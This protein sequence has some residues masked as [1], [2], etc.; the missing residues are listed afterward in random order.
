MHATGLQKVLGHLA[1]LLFAALISG[2]FSIGHLAAPYIDPTALTAARF[3]LAAMVMGLLGIVVRRHL[4]LI[5]EAPWRFII[6]G[7]L[8][9][10]YFV[11][12]FYGLKIASPVSMGAVF[13]LIPLMSAVFGWFL[14]RQRAAPTVILALLVGAAGAL[15]VIFRGDI[16][17]MLRFEVGRGEL[18]FFAGCVAHALYAPM[19]RKL[20]RGEQILGFT[21]MTLVGSLIC[22]IAWG[23][24]SVLNTNWLLL[25]SIVWVAVV[26]LAVFTT[27]GT[28]F[29][30]QY[31][32]MRLP[33]SK[34]M[35]YGYLTPGIVLV[36]EMLLGHGAASL[37]LLTGVV[38]TAA[39]LII[40]AV[41]TDY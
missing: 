28:F 21:F 34:V 15:W 2:S 19:V 39:A 4:P 1:M 16:G 26:Y 36:Y 33:A 14:L 20:N 10:F 9:A 23:A 11:M 41:A 12:M 5:K 6:L 7:G 25:P 8:M 32:S 40:L 29:L 31:A 18:I 22:M 30:L 37:T 38:V 24:P 13:T 3:V 35:A 27:A 17:A